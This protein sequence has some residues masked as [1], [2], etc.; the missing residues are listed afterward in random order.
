MLQRYHFDW[1]DILAFY[2]KKL[3][4]FRLYIHF[5][6]ST[7]WED[8]GGSSFIICSELLSGDPAGVVEPSES[9][10]EP[11]DFAWGVG[12]VLPPESPSLN[13]PLYLC[14]DLCPLMVITVSWVN[15]VKWCS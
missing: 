11:V 1:Q 13:L 12:D 9:A 15:C 8:E 4:Q 5:V 10:L 7:A 6:H 3:I 14:G 2:V